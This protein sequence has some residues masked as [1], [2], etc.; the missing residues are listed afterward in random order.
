MHLLQTREPTCRGTR[1]AV[2][3]FP[4]ATPSSHRPPAAWQ[5]LDRVTA[6]D[7]LHRECNELPGP[8]AQVLWWVAFLSPGKQP[9]G[10]LATWAWRRED[11]PVAP[12]WLPPAAF[13]DLGSPG[14]VPDPI[15]MRPSDS[16]TTRPGLPFA[17][18]TLAPVPNTRGRRGQLPSWDG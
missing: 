4:P 12:G 15:N 13:A 10:R 16:R 7:G 18:R 17:A 2:L 1:H 14:T 9:R 8:M 3:D 6:P 11:S 5:P